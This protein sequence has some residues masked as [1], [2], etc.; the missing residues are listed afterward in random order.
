MYVPGGSALAA[1]LPPGPVPAP[2]EVVER[3][4]PAP[5]VD[6]SA[7]IAT[8]ATTLV[9]TRPLMLAILARFR[10]QLMNRGMLRT[11]AMGK[12]LELAIAIL[13]GAVGDHLS[14]SDNG[15]ATKMTCIAGG[16][17]LPM[18]RAALTRTHPEAT[19]RVAILVHGL[20]CTEDIWLHEDGSDY[21]S[22]LERDHG[23]TPLYLR[24]NSGLP[25]ADNGVALALLLD[26]LVAEYPVPIEEIVPIGYSMGGLVV[27]SACHVAS[28]ARE[29]EGTALSNAWLPLVR[30]AIYVG[31]PHLG[32]PLER[33]GRFVSKVLRAVDDPY[34]QLAA[35][36]ADLRSDGLKDLGD[37]D[38]RHEDRA[39]RLPSVSLRDPRHPVPLLPQIQHFLVAGSLSTDVRLASVFGDSIVPVGS[40]TDGSCI[41]VAT[42]ALPPSHVKIVSGASHVTLAHDAA[43]YE[44]LRTWCAPPQKEET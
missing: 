8:Q 14:R 43:V 16:R 42:F 9:A 5:A 33:V 36:L 24:Y 28:V 27:R 25:I 15:L 30:R 38:L 35:E 39:R 7:A 37:A 26:R 40:A 2:A 17:E 22:L 23:F 34:T 4:Q 10:R 11:G 12:K 19:P 13:N 44:H 3:L 6:A 1:V 29:I 41:D 18:E 21:G 20:M 32:A 31:T